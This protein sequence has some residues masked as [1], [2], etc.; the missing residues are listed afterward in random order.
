MTVRIE[1][2][3]GLVLMSPEELHAEAARQDGE[4]VIRL[5]AEALK[6]RARFSASIARL[7]HHPTVC[8]R[9]H[10]DPTTQLQENR[11]PRRFFHARAAVTPLS[12]FT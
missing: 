2:T 10:S 4:I 7:T 12:G 3:D 11:P 5:S 9:A 6:S 1:R 8:S